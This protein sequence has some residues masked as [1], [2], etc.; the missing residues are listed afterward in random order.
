[1]VVSQVAASLESASSSSKALGLLLSDE[2]RRYVA[3]SLQA[4]EQNGMHLEPDAMKRVEDMKKELSSLEVAP[5]HDDD[6]WG[7]L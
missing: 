2:E 6:W 3:K 7:C 5:C 4:Y 1:M